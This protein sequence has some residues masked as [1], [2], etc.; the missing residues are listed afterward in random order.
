VALNVGSRQRSDTLVLGVN[1]KWPGSRSKR[2]RW[3]CAPRARTI[4]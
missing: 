3:P 1:R 2:R 4:S